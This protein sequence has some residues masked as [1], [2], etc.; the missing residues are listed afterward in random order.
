MHSERRGEER[1]II[2]LRFS[3]DLKILPNSSTACCV[4]D[5]HGK[6]QHCDDAIIVGP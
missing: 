1:G 6:P 4:I 3:L 5:A 2:Q